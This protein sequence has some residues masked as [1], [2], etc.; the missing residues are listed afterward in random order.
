MESL[1]G[2]LAARLVAVFM[3]PSSLIVYTLVPL[4]LTTGLGHRIYLR[5][6]DWRSTFSRLT[7][8]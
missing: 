5:V 4:T 8:N 6:E 2:E 3:R 1:A 7:P